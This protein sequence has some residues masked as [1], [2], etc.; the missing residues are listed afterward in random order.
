MRKFRLIIILLLVSSAAIA[1]PPAKKD[2]I[3]YPIRKIT[4]DYSFRTDTMPIDTSIA[5]LQ[6]LN[7]AYLNEHSNISLV[8]LGYPCMS[9]NII[10]RIQN[11]DIFFPANVFVPYIQ[12]SKDNFFYDTRKPYTSLT[13]KNEGVQSNNEEYLQIIHTQNINKKTNIG[14]FYN[15]YS[16]YSKYNIQEATDHALNVFYRYS[17]NNFLTY[18]LF[19]YNSFSIQENGGIEYDSLVN[20]STG[21]YDG[22]QVNLQ[23]ASSKFKRVGF[24]SINEFKLKA[25]F[26]K[27]NDTT[28]IQAKDYGSIIY[29]FNY[30]IR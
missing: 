28:G 5:K 24:N 15:L 14:L 16:S 10:T 21:T 19:Y 29:N 13:Y 12:D 17:G 7:P 30:R 25:L 27:E 1:N 6:I 20:Y 11:N 9:N 18:N 8:K 26:E 2:S 23:E 3:P 22:L 4:L